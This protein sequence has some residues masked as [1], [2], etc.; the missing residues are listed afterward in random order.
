[1]KTALLGAPTLALLQ[2]AGSPPA[3]AKLRKLEITAFAI[4]MSN[5]ATGATAVVD[6]T[7]NSWSTPEEREMLITTMLE[8]GPDALLRRCRSRR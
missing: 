3:Q 6:I 7:I 1:M 2:S 5:I 4:N 8:K